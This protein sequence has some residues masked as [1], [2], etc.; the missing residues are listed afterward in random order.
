MGVVAVGARPADTDKRH[1]IP[2]TA[3]L[4]AAHGVREIPHG[5]G[6]QVHHA[7]FFPEQAAVCALGVE[8]SGR[9]PAFGLQAR[10]ADARTDRR[11]EPFADMDVQRRS[12]ALPEF[13]FG[14][15]LTEIKVHTSGHSDENIIEKAIGFI[16][17]PYDAVLRIPVPVFLGR[18]KS[19]RENKQCNNVETFHFSGY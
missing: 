11:R 16:R 10:V 17:P 3:L 9:G 1:E 15:V 4:V 6:V 5:V 7:E 8:R 14:V 2:R 12:Q 18:S 13:S 19:A